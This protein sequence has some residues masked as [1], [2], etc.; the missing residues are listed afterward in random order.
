MVSDH[1]EAAHRF[2]LPALI[3][4]FQNDAEQGLENFGL[5]PLGNA[6]ARW[7]AKSPYSMLISTSMMVSMDLA[8]KY[9][10]TQTTP[11]QLFNNPLIRRT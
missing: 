7:P 10:S 9:L 5:D 6:S 4:Q 1:K 11:S 8:E 3:G 2:P